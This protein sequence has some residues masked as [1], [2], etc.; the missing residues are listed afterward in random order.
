MALTAVYIV[1][2][3]K[4]EPGV[5]AAVVAGLKKLGHNVS[6]YVNLSSCFSVFHCFISMSRLYNW[7][8]MIC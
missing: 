4:I 1:L 8:K 7:E 2:Q 6:R 5:D 3:V